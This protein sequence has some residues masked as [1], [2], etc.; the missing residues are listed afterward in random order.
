MSATT[1]LFRAHSPPDV[2]CAG[3]VANTLPPG[4]DILVI[5]TDKV[6]GDPGA[7]LKTLRALSQIHRWSALVDISGIALNRPQDVGRS[8]AGRLRR[9][10][11]TVR[12]M[13][14]LRQRLAPA[15]GIDPGQKALSEAVAD[16]LDELYV[17]CLTHPDIQA[18]YQLFPASKK[19][20][21]P[22]T[23]DSLG[24][25]E[26]ADYEALCSPGARGNLPWSTVVRD[27]LKSSLVGSDACPQRF[28]ELDTAYSFNAPLCWAKSQVSLRSLVNRDTM[29]D[30][31]RYLPGDVRRYHDDLAERYRRGTGLLLLSPEDFYKDMDLEGYVI[32]AR[33]LVHEGARA[34]LVK[35]HPRSGKEYI[36][37]IMNRLDDEVQDVALVLLDGYYD[38]PIEITLAPFTLMGCAALVSTT[39]ATL[40]SYYRVPVYCPRDWLLRAFAGDP[41][42]RQIIDNWLIEY[43][44]RYVA[45]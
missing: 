22:H 19:S 18:L 9:V 37:R 14:E 33:R 4:K 28:L 30:L 39:I 26:C 43:E 1:R 23:F 21:Y 12:S 5:C 6:H 2:V 45:S 44:G 11:D 24:R 35:P 32:M 29:E 40:S 7:Y 15:L 8:V 17:A 38:Y 34:L 31:Y 13:H 36:H 27:C 3:L 25:E 16:G 10:V 41:R 42:K 20:I